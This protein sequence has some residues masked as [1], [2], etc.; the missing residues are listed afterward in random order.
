MP[1]VCQMCIKS[2]VGLKR[3]ILKE[4][5]TVLVI[6]TIWDKGIKYLR[7]F[8]IIEIHNNVGNLAIPGDAVDN[9]PFFISLT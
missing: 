9:L 8:A 3:Q 7:I 2:H 1:H 5:L 6:V 4:I